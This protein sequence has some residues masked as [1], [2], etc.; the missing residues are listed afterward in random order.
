MEWQLVDRFQG[1]WHGLFM[2]VHGQANA[3]S[4]RERSVACRDTQHGKQHGK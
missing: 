1:Y 4:H 3:P 2:N